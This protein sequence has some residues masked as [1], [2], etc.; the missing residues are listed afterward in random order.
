MYTLLATALAPLRLLPVV[1][2]KSDQ[3]SWLKVLMVGSGSLFAHCCHHPKAELS[4]LLPTK[5]KL[6]PGI[7]P[8][9]TVSTTALILP[10]FCALSLLQSIGSTRQLHPLVWQ[11]S[12]MAWP[13]QEFS[14]CY[15]RLDFEP[16]D[17]PHNNSVMVWYR[18][19]IPAEEWQ[20]TAPAAAASPAV[21]PAAWPASAE[22]TCW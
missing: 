17:G 15:G 8:L 2:P 16:F 10:L 9:W 21:G 4:V 20:Q 11:D 1:P 5:A 22:V 14:G 3:Q 13:E 6:N 12:A 19:A 7:M 18:A